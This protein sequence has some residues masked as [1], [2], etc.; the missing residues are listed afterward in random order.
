MCGIL[1]YLGD[2]NF[3]PEA[4]GRALDTMANRGPDDRGVFERPEI[5]LGHRR[6]AILDLSASGHQPMSSPDGRYTIVFNGEIYNFKEL[7]LPLER[8]GVRF[9]SQSDTEVILHLYQRLGAACLSLFEGMFAFAI[10]DA[11][12]RTLFLA[13]DRL[14]IKPLYCWKQGRT[15]VFASE[16]KA[17]RA[18]PGG[19]RDVEP[20]AV[21]AYL[22]WGSVPE[23]K[24]ITLGVEALP[25][26][27]WALW[28][29]GQLRVE[30][31]WR[32]PEPTSE[33]KSRAE[34]I[35][36]L[37]PV[38]RKAVALRCISDAPLGA[39]LSGG[40]DSS[41]VVSLMRDAGQTDLRTFSI[42]FPQSALDEGPYALR[43][44]EKF[45]TLHTDISVTEQMV[46]KELDGFFLALDQPTCDGLNTY[47]VSKFTR[48]GG[49]TV[50][51]SGIGGDE[52]FAGYATFKR[53]RNAIPVVRLL[54]RFAAWIGS[55][56]H[57][58]A[59]GR[60][61]KLEA[62]SLP[63]SA[64]DRLYFASRGLF[65]PNQVRTLLSASVNEQ[66]PSDWTPM[67][68]YGI[69]IAPW[70]EASPRAREKKSILHIVA[71][72]EV[73]HYMRNQLLRDS[74]VLGMSRSL[75]IRVPLLDFSLL[76]TIFRIAPHIIA[77]RP[78]KSLLI[79]ALS[80][81]LPDACIHRPKMGFTLPFETWMR[82]PWASQ[83]KILCAEC[84]DLLDSEAC[85]AVWRSYERGLTHWSR[86]WSLLTLKRLYT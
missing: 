50:A 37:R 53:I 31:Y 11:R 74:D 5:I 60:A 46:H 75:E 61:S 2:R 48:Q 62:L 77:K 25:P 21:A 45:G 57:G 17:I 22:A 38:L 1:G 24:T 82:G 12:D 29:G 15:L 63:G 54:P 4:F 71:H 9:A 85:L 34:A 64:I 43:V 39:F 52:L 81:S 18:L 32:I 58:I 14:G 83:M 23:P 78:A 16:V 10:W 6:L 86:P 13:R 84:S 55:Q 56:V 76:E 35:E 8:E 65:M 59:R 73:S 79:E 51:L 80:T 67:D 44:A 69:G 30:P 36:L 40:I 26:G 27:H 47:L 3:G 19:P 33:V 42:S 49:L 72:H 68:P 66:L 41:A 28:G 20:R 70:G 7:R